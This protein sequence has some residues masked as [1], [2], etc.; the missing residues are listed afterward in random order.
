M[1]RIRGKPFGK[2][3]SLRLSY[4]PLARRQRLNLVFAGAVFYLAF[5]YPEEFN[6]DCLFGNAFEQKR[7]SGRMVTVGERIS[8]RAKGGWLDALCA[9][10]PGAC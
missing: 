6:P 2:R 5:G 8:P 10:Q 7:R 3:L 4:C 9:Q 1:K